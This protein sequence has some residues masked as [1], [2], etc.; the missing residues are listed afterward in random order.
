MFEKM[1]VLIIKWLQM[2]KIVPVVWYLQIKIQVF[3]IKKSYQG[4]NPPRDTAPSQNNTT[5]NKQH[6]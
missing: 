5:I 6:T 1:M 4:D 3:T 2:T